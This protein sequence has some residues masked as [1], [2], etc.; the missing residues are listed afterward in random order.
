[1]TITGCCPKEEASQLKMQNR[2]LAF[3]CMRGKAKRLLKRTDSVDYQMF[4]TL[5]C[6]SGKGEELTDGRATGA[7]PL[8]KHRSSRNSLECRQNISTDVCSRV[9]WLDTF[10]VGF[11]CHFHEGCYDFNAIWFVSFTVSKVT[12]EQQG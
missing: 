1:M 6:L 7:F 8:T 12:Q 2:D 3:Q 10:S 4:C 5:L 11:L 9:G